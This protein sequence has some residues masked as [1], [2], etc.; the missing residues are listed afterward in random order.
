MNQW[1]RNFIQDIKKVDDLS[2][3][4]EI[5]VFAFSFLFAAAIFSFNILIFEKD[6]I[7]SAF[8]ILPIVIASWYVGLKSGI[9]LSVFCLAEYS[10]LF[11]YYQVQ[12]FNL[13]VF[14]ISFIPKMV[15]Y[16]FIVYILVRLKKSLKAERLLA[17]I[18]SLTR[19]GNRKSLYERVEL[20]MNNLRRYNKIFA[21]VYFDIDDFKKLNDDYG[22]IEGDRILKTFTNR[23]NGTIRKNDALFRVGGDEFI[24]ILPQT[25]L[26]QSKIVMAKIKTSLN[27]P[28]E[29]SKKF[30]TAS[31]GVGIFT[32]YIENI[33][34]VVLYVDKLMI[35]VKKSGK[36]NVDYYEF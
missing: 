14:L 31:A 7:F 27:E 36:N 2:K 21:L 16:F 18:D 6:A 34:D 32:V 29:E 22:H 9:F 4:D 23:I 25:N 3:K 1:F 17:R 26:E 35:K 19:I 15:V 5:A 8:Y 10:F 28:D 30:P 11:I 13:N 24:L 12:T 20:E 33:E